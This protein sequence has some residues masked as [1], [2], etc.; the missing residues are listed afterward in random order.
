MMRS[1][2]LRILSLP[3]VVVLFLAWYPGEVEATEAAW[4]LIAGGGYTIFLA[5]ADAPGFGDPPYFDL[6]DCSTQRN[7][8][9]RGRQQASRWGVRI[10]TRATPISRIYAS[11]WCR[12]M[13]TATNAFSSQPVEPLAALDLVEEGDDAAR[14]ANNAEIMDLIRGFRGPGNQ[15]M[16]THNEVVESLTG[17]TPRNGEALIVVPAKSPGDGDPPLR[18]V[19]EIL[20]N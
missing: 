18:V 7:L 11:R 6:S 15:V 4:A 12:T 16:V 10:A 13:D 2:L 1:R 8:S 3:V 14:A 9:D 5:N 20:L 19:N 17:V